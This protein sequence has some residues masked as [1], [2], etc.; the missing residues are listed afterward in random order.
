MSPPE[1]TQLPP[2]DQVTRASVCWI[3][4]GGKGRRYE[5]M[6]GKDW[7]LTTTAE[8]YKPG[9][10]HDVTEEEWVHRFYQRE[11]Q[12][13]GNAGKKTHTEDAPPAA[14]SWYRALLNHPGV[15]SAPAALDE[16]CSNERGLVVRVHGGV[17]DILLDS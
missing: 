12:V 7:V 14:S 8:L 1:F 16:G 15:R 17:D 10:P 11:K 6:P 13:Q 2:A 3:A 9:M 4:S 5:A